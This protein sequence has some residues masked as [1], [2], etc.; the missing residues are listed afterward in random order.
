MYYFI[1]L[2]NK[3][4]ANLMLVNYQAYLSKALIL[5]SSSANSLVL[6]VAILFF[7]NAGIDPLGSI[8]PIFVTRVLL[9]ST[10]SMINPPQCAKAR[11][12]SS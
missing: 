3:K 5:P 9:Y 11:T 1:R 2:I 4:I 10:F 8:S 6:S 7:K 12:V